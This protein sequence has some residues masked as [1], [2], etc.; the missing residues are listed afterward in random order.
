MC[1]HGRR[2]ILIS[3]KPDAKATFLGGSAHFLLAG[4]R[5]HQST[6]DLETPDAKAV[7]LARRLGGTAR[8]VDPMATPYTRLVYSPAALVPRATSYSHSTL[9]PCFFA[10]LIRCF[11]CFRHPCMSL[12]TSRLYTHSLLCDFFC[13]QFFSV[14]CMCSPLHVYLSSVILFFSLSHPTA[15]LPSLT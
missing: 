11:F 12:C 3:A 10:L 14:F 7:F 15:T 2:H 9:F 4:G 1:N 13:T 5:V 8:W 6:P